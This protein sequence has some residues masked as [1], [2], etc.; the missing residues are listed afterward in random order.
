M[1]MPRISAMQFMKEICSTV[2]EWLVMKLVRGGSM[3][4]YSRLSDLRSGVD[5][6]SN[7]VGE[8][9]IPRRPMGP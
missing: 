1:A 8:C 2:L 6:G 4:M 3:K 5:A 7:G 9:R